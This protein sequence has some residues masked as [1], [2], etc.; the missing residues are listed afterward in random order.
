M[1]ERMP[2][3]S[4]TR[5][6]CARKMGSG[7]S[8]DGQWRYSIPLLHVT[9][10]RREAL[11]P[12][13]GV[14]LDADDLLYYIAERLQSTG[15][16]AETREPAT[17]ISGD[18]RLLRLPALEEEIVVHKRPVQLG[19]AHISKRVLETKTQRSVPEAGGGGAHPAGSI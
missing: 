14:D 3:Y 9:E 11:H 10:V 4:P 6:W 19:T 13:V 8:E 1:P 17:T 7:G 15:E 5:C 2:A 18:D 12:L 16:S